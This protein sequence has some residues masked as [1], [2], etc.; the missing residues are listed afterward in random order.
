MHPLSASPSQEQAKPKKPAFEARDEAEPWRCIGLPVLQ[1]EAGLQVS[2]QNWW[3]EHRHESV[4]ERA[5]GFL[6]CIQRYGLQ[7]QA[8]ARFLAAL[9]IKAG[10]AG[11]A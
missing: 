11:G 9:K 10:E 1:G 6:E 5:A 8:G 7:A 2:W 4:P 3:F